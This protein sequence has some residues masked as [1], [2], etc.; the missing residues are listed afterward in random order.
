VYDLAEGA[1]I[2]KTLGDRKAVILA[3]H[4][5]L[6][7]GTSVDEAVWWFVTMERSCQVQLMVEAAGGGRLIPD[8][9]ARHT[10]GQI[11]SHIAGWLS[12]QSLYDWIVATEPDVLDD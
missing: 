9:V 5:H 1:R 8:D 4:G 2:A 6:T 12:F 10:W 11:G 7:V 3:N